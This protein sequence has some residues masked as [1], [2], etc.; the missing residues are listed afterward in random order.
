MSLSNAMEN[1]LLLFLLNNTDFA[2]IGDAGGLRGSVVAGS[3]W[4]ALFTA[5]PGEAGTAVT[6]ETAYTG[7]ARKASA[8]SGAG[9]VVTAGSASP[10][11]DQTFGECTAAAGGAIT[12]FGLVSSASGA[13]VLMWSGTYTPN[14]TMAIGVAPVLKATSTVT[15]D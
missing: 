2:G 14:V 15:L 11:A 1:S 9:I 7:Y 10:A 13:G 4:W 5:D 8:R 3:L 12:H 6:N